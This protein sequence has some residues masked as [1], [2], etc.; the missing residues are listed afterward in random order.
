MKENRQKQNRLI[1]APIM[2]YM[3]LGYGL[4]YSVYL[5]ESLTVRLL[6][7]CY[8]FTPFEF[9]ATAWHDGADWII[10]A[11][12]LAW[13]ILT[14]RALLLFLVAA[15]CACSERFFTNLLKRIYFGNKNR[16]NKL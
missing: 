16:T 10:L 11:F 9:R 14:L 12:P 15:T 4:L 1:M 7:Y 3:L 6:G 5:V 2:A 8:L 13:P